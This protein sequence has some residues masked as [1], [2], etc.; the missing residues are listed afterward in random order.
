MLKT[1]IL[2][3]VLVLSSGAFANA[4][5]LPAPVGTGDGAIIRVADGCGGGW[6]RGPAGRCRPIRGPIVVAPGAVVVA[7]GLGLLA[8]FR[9][10]VY[11]CPPGMHLGPEGRHC[12]PNR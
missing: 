3:A 12:W 9:G 2:G 10:G 6:Y 7:P 5:M 1:L 4:A 11:A 8:V